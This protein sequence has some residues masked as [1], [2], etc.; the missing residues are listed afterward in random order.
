MKPK[1]ST[2][3]A[4]HG[5]E[6]VIERNQ[7]VYLIVRRAMVAAVLSLVAL[8]VSVV[9]AI[10]IIFHPAPPVYL[11]VTSDGHLLPLIP[12]DRPNVGRGE[13]GAFAL[14]AAHAVNTYD[15]I[16]YLDQLSAASD[17]FSPAG[18][19]QYEQKLG[20]SR[21]LDAV[22]ER[23]MIVSIKPLGEVSIP[24]EGTNKQGL[25][26]WQVIIPVEIDYTAHIQ[27]QSG[28]TD[29]GN[30][31]DGSIVMWISRVPTTVNARGMAVQV[32]RLRLD[33]EQGVIPLSS[34]TSAQPASQ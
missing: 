1:S 23:K 11:P 20:E 13:V 18:W 10:G 19:N 3:H 29:P 5:A 12:L 30:R 17:Y 21:T 31:Q 2:R 4:K 9:C 16:N 15:Y 32:Y 25:Y 8:A 26:V 27:T 24:S 6:L 22:R 7:A 34:S 14:E 33:G 28:G